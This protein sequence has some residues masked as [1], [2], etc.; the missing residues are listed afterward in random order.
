MR[1]INFD[2][3][4][5]RYVG[6]WMKEHDREYRN[7]DEME[8]AMPDVYAAFLDTPVNALGNLVT[9]VSMITLGGKLK[10]KAFG[11]NRNAILSVNVIRLILI[12]LVMLAI[13]YAFG[14]R[15]AE[16]YMMLVVFGTPVAVASYPMAVNMGGD[17]E[18]AGQIVFTSTVV[19]LFT[20]FAFTFMLAQLGLIV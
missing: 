13:G 17:G 7:Y 4:F 5:E 19:S 8:A 20:I 14:L 1:C 9:P 3:E 12:P 10:F 11:K 2:K 18:L 16:L 15:Q 6:A